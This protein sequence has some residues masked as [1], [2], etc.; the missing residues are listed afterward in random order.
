M[1]DPNQDCPQGLSL[2]DYSIRSCGRGGPGHDKCYSVTFP[3][4]GPQ[5][6]HVCGRVTAYRWGGNNGFFWL[7]RTTTEH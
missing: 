4:D 7:S 5:Y 2:T 3:V 1:T 6:T